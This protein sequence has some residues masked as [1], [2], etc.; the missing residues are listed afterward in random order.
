MVNQEEAPVGTLLP[1]S[2]GQKTHPH[3]LPAGPHGTSPGRAYVTARLWGAAVGQAGPHVPG[4]QR[5][6]V[7]YWGREQ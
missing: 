6:I 2:A 4:N 5:A 7:L 1:L 3:T